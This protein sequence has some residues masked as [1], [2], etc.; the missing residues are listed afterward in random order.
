MAGLRDLKLRIKATRSIASVT[1]AMA[2]IANAKLLNAQRRADVALAFSSDLEKAVL[3]IQVEPEDVVINPRVFVI[4]SDAGLCGSHNTLLH[5]SISKTMAEQMEEHGLKPEFVV[6]GNKLKGPLG[7]K[8]H[9]QGNLVSMVSNVSKKM[10]FKQV[11]EIIDD[12]SVDREEAGETQYHFQKLTGFKSNATKDTIPSSASFN[13]AP[14]M[15][16]ADAGVT[17]NS[18]ITDYLQAAMFYR[19][20]A[21]SECAELSARNS[22]MLNASKAAKDMVDELELLYR[23]LRQAKV[24]TEIIEIS[25]GAQAVMAED[26][27]KK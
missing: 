8:F 24:T 19:S 18:N 9:T 23:K 5:R 6:S 4:G 3:G 14:A 12:V 10:N 7:N 16:I 1:E 27:A 13:A 26:A 21:L 11:S 2:N 15:E 17:T 20:V 22:A 25:S